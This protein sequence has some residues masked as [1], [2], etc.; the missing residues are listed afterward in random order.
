MHILAFG[1]NH[2][3]API[4]IREKFYLNETQQELLLSELKHRSDVLAAVVV[5]TCNRIEVYCEVTRSDISATDILQQFFEVKKVAWHADLA[6]Y[7]YIYH[8]EEALRHI[9]RVVSSVDSL[10]L[11]EKQILGQIKKAFDLSH[12]RQMLSR[13]FNILQQ[14]VVR[15]GKLVH[16]E[17][18]IGYGGTSVSWAAVKF[19]AEKLDSLSGKSVMVVGS[20]QMGQLALRQLSLLDIDDLFIMNRTK[21]KAEDAAHEYNAKAVSFMHLPKLLKTVDVC[22]CAVDAPHYVIEKEVIDMI[23]PERK[24]PLLMIDISM[25]RNIDPVIDDFEGVSVYTID[26]LDGHL[27]ASLQKRRAAIPAVNKIIDKKMSALYEKIEKMNT[28]SIADVEISFRSLI[29]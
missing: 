22:I 20:G 4:E 9:L 3:T 14:I 19:A 27:E 26:D 13:Y 12:R 6:N 1:L 17:T 15:T 23:L 10:V 5:S 8:Q 16:S 28:F 11:G 25:P 18:D 7:F 2:K 29:T 21:E 24:A